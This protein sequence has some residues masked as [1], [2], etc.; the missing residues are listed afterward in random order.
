MKRTLVVLLVLAAIGGVAWLLRAKIALAYLT[1]RPTDP[2]TLASLAGSVLCGFADDAEVATLVRTHMRIGAEKTVAEEGVHV[3]V[4]NSG[5]FRDVYG[6]HPERLDAALL[7]DHFTMDCDGNCFWSK[8]GEHPVLDPPY[9]LKGREKSAPFIAGLRLAAIRLSVLRGQRAKYDSQ[10]SFL[11]MAKVLADSAKSPDPELA[12][13]I[14][15]RAYSVEPGEREAKWYVA[16]V[17]RIAG[18]KKR[19]EAWAR[20]I[21]SNPEAETYR[22]SWNLAMDEILGAPAPFDPSILRALA[23]ECVKRSNKRADQPCVDLGLSSGPKW[24][25]FLTEIAGGGSPA[26]AGAKALLAEQKKV[27]EQSWKQILARWKEA[28]PSEVSK[29]SLGTSPMVAAGN[30]SPSRVEKREIAALEKTGE[31][32]LPPLLKLYRSTRNWR[33]IRAA[34]E[35]L[36]RGK[37]AALAKIAVQELVPMEPMARVFQNGEKVNM[38]DYG[39]AGR[40]VAHALIQLEVHGAAAK[41]PMPFMLALSVPDAAF[42]THASAALR[43]T[44]SSDQ[45]ADALFRF[46]AQRKRFAVW[47]VDLYEDALTSFKGVG[48]AITRNLGRLLEEAGGKPQKVSWIHKVIAL[49]SLRDVGDATAVATLR[50]FARDPGTYSYVV[51]TV[52]SEGRKRGARNTTKRFSELA[53]AALDEIAKRKIAQPTEGK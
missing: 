13:A 41:N 18:P 9:Y 37:P 20:A 42:S 44:L 47:E 12:N 32:P 27:L 31:E 24:T 51:T 11:A 22:W 4:R 14:A 34:A 16:S 21:T 5:L 15:S 46:L 2:G 53:Q 3:P 40:R 50:D 52:D 48:P 25:A 8:I 30:Q 17:G 6:K 23:T 49:N 33:V 1:D 29:Y 45:F 35:V 43:R 26:K 10:G 28:S 39:T 7:A 38:T 36:A 19:G